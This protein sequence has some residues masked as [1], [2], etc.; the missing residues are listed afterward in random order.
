MKIY[1]LTD[2]EIKNLKWELMNKRSKSFSSP[3]TLSDSQSLSKKFLIY[4]NKI[5]YWIIVIFSKKIK[6]I[7]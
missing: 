6:R 4:I 5:K 3:E 7:Y 2:D 1:Y